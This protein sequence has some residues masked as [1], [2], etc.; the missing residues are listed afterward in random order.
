MEPW[1]MREEHSAIALRAHLAL[2]I[3]DLAIWDALS[4]STAVLIAAAEQLEVS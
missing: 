1:A 2:W 4:P 3:Y